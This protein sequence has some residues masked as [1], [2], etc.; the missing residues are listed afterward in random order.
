[1]VDKCWFAKNIEVSQAY[2]N[3]EASHG[4]VKLCKVAL[5]WHMGSKC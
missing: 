1:M 4:E 3:Y 5:L 2:Q